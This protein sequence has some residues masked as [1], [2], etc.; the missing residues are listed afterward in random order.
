MKSTLLDLMRTSPVFLFENDFTPRESDVIFSQSGLRSNLPNADSFRI[1]NT[2]FF[3]TKSHGDILVL[4]YVS[5]TRTRGSADD[6]G[7]VRS[8]APGVSVDT[9][10]LDLPEKF[11]AVAYNFKTG[12]NEDEEGNDDLPRGEAENINTNV[13]SP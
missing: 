6:G 8:S 1:S 7:Q 4:R 10:V 3:R 12:G 13:T 11:R 2:E 9:L 5:P